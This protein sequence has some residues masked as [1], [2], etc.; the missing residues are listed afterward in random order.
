MITLEN[1]GKTFG[2]KAVIKDL[3][4]VFDGGRCYVISGKSGCGKSTLL[5]LI[6]G[7]DKKHE[8]RISGACRVSMSF[9]DARLFPWLN[10]LE[11]AAVGLNGSGADKEK[12]KSEASSLLLRLGLSKSDFGSAAG[13]LSGGMQARV[14]IARALLRDADTYL[15][16][17]PFANLD[18][19][20]ALSCADVIRELTSARGKICLIVSHA[21]EPPGSVR[22]ECAGDPF[23]SFTDI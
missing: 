10:A 22:L 20:T 21:V 2:A 4:Y 8:G 18:Q 11:N 14:G 17:E 1:V 15:F 3:S 7:L 19:A 5:R 9:Q 13:E 12:K 16:D 6:A 23:G